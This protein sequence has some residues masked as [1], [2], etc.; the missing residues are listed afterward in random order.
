MKFDLNKK[1]KKMLKNFKNRKKNVL[2]KV[3]SNDVKVMSFNI[4]DSSVTSLG[5]P[6]SSKLMSFS[7]SQTLQHE[8]PM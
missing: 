2:K 4:S 6:G 8:T 7:Y 3:M 1:N 5:L